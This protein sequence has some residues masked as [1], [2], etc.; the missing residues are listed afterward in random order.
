MIEA[1]YVFL[2][3]FY[4]INR[5]FSTQSILLTLCFRLHIYD[6]DLKENLMQL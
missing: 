1:R 3:L 5:L 6:S 2:Y 4:I